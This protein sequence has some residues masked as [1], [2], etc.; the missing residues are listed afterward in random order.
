MHIFD[1]VTKISLRNK[2][3]FHL[4]AL[5]GSKIDHKIEYSQLFVR[6]CL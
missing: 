1:D 6:D 4:I 2:T 5:D 3:K